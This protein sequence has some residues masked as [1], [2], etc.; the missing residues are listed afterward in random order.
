MKR[1]EYE[2]EHWTADPLIKDSTE[3]DYLNRRAA[4]GWKLVAVVPKETKYYWKRE[5]K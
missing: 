5:M 1:F 4:L 2:I 3:Q